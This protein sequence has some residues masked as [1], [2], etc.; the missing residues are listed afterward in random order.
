MFLAFFHF[1]STSLQ[2]KH[3]KAQRRHRYRRQAHHNRTL[4]LS[5]G[6]EDDDQ[7]YGPDSFNSSY[8]EISDL[9]EGTNEA[10]V[11]PTLNNSIPKHTPG[12]KI[13]YNSTPLNHHLDEAEQ[14]VNF[15]SYR[16]NLSR[17]S[18]E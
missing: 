2:L 9:D 8:C 1:V 5:G 15:R 12:L 16:S 4:L 10:S 11:T 13:Q 17:T 3:R 6:D 7:S 18:L 14:C